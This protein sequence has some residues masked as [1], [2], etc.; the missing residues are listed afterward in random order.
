MHGP[1]FAK[2]PPYWIIVFCV[3][4]ALLSEA[5]SRAG[6]LQGIETAY[7]DL[8]FRLAGQRTQVSHVALVELDDQTLAMHPD[9]PLVFWTPH[10]ARALQ[11]LRNVEARVVGLDFLFSAS[12]E[13]WFGKISG[14]DSQVA[15]SFDRSFRQEIASGRV[16]LGGMQ[17]GAEALLP[18]ADY[19]AVLPEFSIERFVGAT[20]LVMDSDG[21]LRKM[22]TLAPGAPLAADDGVR[23]LPFSLL[24]A[25]QA[26][27]QANDAASWRFGNREFRRDSVPWPLAWAGPPGTVPRLPLRRL[28]AKDAESDPEVRALKDKVVIIGV[29]Y[30]GSNDVHLTPY[31][32]GLFASQWMRGPEIQ[33]QA[34]DALLAGRFVEVLPTGGRALLIGVILLL[35]AAG[36]QR[37]AVG[38]GALLLLALLAVIAIGGHVAHRQWLV[39]PVAQAQFAALLLFLTIYALRFTSGERDRD[40]VRRMFSRYVSKDVVARL[41]ESDETPVLGGEAVR[42]TVLF[43]DIR[44]FTTISERLSPEEVV[45]MLN[46]W[47]AAA[48]TAVQKE[49]GSVDKFIGD[50]IMA[51]FGAPL[52]C[53]DHARRALR[54]AIALRDAAVEMA[55][56]MKERFSDRDLPDFGI[57]VGIH[58]GRAVVG[59]IGAPERM[60]YT[61]IGDTVNLASRLE[62]ATRTLNCAIAASRA[63]IDEAGSGIITGAS[64]T[65][66]VKGREAPVE[67]LAVLGIEDH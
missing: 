67:V 9:D 65:I 13:H 57:G 63:A 4:V 35:G 3:I 25:L 24:L 31:G 14:Q 55:A 23:L 27:G 56:W 32:H 48:C 51:E 59:N 60:E 47:L 8:S 43:S 46:R 36:W 15:R 5:V 42:I 29:A 44:G 10:F 20:D 50:A 61:A 52:H 17:S 64:Q 45:E 19:L 38:R 6:W 18:A 39:V 1:S 37:L 33:A 40:R 16:V 2:K 54:A 21:I 34:V 11:V 58:S 53:D 30:G 28:L 7:G 62:G 12:P 49:G 26:S 41:L 66:A 22:R